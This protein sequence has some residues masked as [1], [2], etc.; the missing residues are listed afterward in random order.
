[1][2]QTLDDDDD[3]HES[4]SDGL[5]EGWYKDLDDPHEPEDEEFEDLPDHPRM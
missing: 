2:Q 1:M 3:H 4:E 5:F